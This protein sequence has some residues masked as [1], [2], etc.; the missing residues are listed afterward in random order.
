MSPF[1]T[2][3]LA[4]DGLAN[5]AIYA[6]LAI[7]LI[8]I[9]SVTRIIFVAL[10]EIVSYAA[11]TY[12]AMLEGSRLGVIAFVGVLAVAGALRQLASDAG[13]LGASRA[14]AGAVRGLVFPL[15]ACIFAFL[16][17]EL[18]API[19]VM[20]VATV[21]LVTAIGP[22]LYRLVYAPIASASILVLLIV[23][24]AVHLALLGMGLYLFGP[25]GGQTPVLIDGTILLGRIPVKNQSILIIVVMLIFMAGLFFAAEK[26]LFGKA[27][28][29]AAFNSIGARLMGV[30]ASLAGETAFT[31]AA[32][33]AAWQAIA[34]YP[35]LAA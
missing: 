25:Q 1:V 13:T 19:L 17:A 22:V 11:M 32:F 4:Q 24:I 3:Y 29:A 12:V 6:L 5:G 34:G 27:M 9:F 8:V 7:A 33:I 26:T 21:L 23:S 18:K 28:R 2:G 31:I 14:L 30:S 15:G 20:L 16:V 35:A 10:G